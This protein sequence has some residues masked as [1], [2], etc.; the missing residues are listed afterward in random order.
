[1]APG[2]LDETTTTQQQLRQLLQRPIAAQRKKDAALVF[3]SYVARA[4][5]APEI[6]SHFKLQVRWICAIC[7][8]HLRD[9]RTTTPNARGKVHN[10]GDRLSGT[11]HSNWSAIEGE[12]NATNAGGDWRFSIRIR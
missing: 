4:I 1:M 9:F 5:R 6:G 11:S 12:H 10:D 7:L 8:D 2:V 3:A